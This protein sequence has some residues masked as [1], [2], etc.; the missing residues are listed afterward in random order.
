M[1]ESSR[2]VLFTRNPE[3][4]RAKTRLVPALG[5]EGAAD[6]QRRMTERILATIDRL[7]DARDVSVE[8]RMAGG[9]LDLARAWLGEERRIR[10]QGPGD[11]GARMHRAFEDASRDGIEATVI[12][13]A[14][15]P[16]I[17]RAHLERAF[18]ALHESELALGPAEDGGY[19]LIG[20]RQPRP[21][22]FIGIPWGEA[23]VF[24]E[25]VRVAEASGIAPALLDVLAD[26]D[27]P[28]DLGTLP[29]DLL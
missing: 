23:T 14:D 16:A 12:V 1:S 15:C 9:T 29:D 6:L 27:R 5:P 4:G 17:T 21:S 8:I 24:A 26:V 7:A 20:L 19:W 13:G 2:V 25:T 11:L 18:D 22:L 3:P 10:P 28:E